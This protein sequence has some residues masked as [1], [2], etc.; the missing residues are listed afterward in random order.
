MNLQVSWPLLV[1]LHLSGCSTTVGLPPQPRRPP[2]PLLL[3]PGVE[4]LALV[5]ATTA[6]GPAFLIPIGCPLCATRLDSARMGSLCLTSPLR[7]EGHPGLCQA[8]CQQFHPAWGRHRPLCLAPSAIQVASLAAARKA[9][10][11]AVAA[12]DRTSVVPAKG[13][14]TG[15]ESAEPACARRR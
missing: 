1:A 3:P 10:E 8:Q 6:E 4:V 13:G 11:V 9:A 2:L 12:V 5:P 7:L 14:H 15:G